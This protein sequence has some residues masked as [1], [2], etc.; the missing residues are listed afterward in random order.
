[1]QAYVKQK[2]S[3]YTFDCYVNK[4]AARVEVNISLAFLHWV[5][6][7]LHLSPFVSDK[8]DI[9]LQPT[10][11]F[12]FYN[13]ILAPQMH[14]FHFSDTHVNN[15]WLQ[16]LYCKIWIKCCYHEREGLLY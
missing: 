13:L 9:K 8:G 3:F 12:D 4:K 11:Y 15:S 14:S 6:I 1:M 5:G 7:A 16:W 2:N 10:H